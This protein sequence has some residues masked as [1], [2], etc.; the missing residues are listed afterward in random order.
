[1]NTQANISFTS[2]VYRD[3]VGLDEQDVVLGAAP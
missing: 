1:M 2:Q 3:W